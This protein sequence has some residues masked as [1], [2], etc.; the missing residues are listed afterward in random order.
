ML[1]PL[2]SAVDRAVVAYLSFQVVD[3]SLV[4]QP[5]AHA[6]QSRPRVQRSLAEHHARRDAGTRSGPHR[7]P[8]KHSTHCISVPRRAPFGA[9]LYVNAA[10]AKA[11]APPGL[12]T[13]PHTVV[14]VPAMCGG[15]AQRP[16]P[17]LRLRRWPIARGDHS[18]ALGYIVSHNSHAMTAKGMVNQRRYVVGA[19]RAA[20]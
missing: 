2:G 4:C 5:R 13:V 15:T 11:L 20:P 14:G 1:T 17:A 16:P 8:P 12:V 18:A 9:Q 6:A 3:S 7:S 19:H 10:G